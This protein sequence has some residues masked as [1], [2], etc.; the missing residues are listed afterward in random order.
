MKKSIKKKIA[1]SATIKNT[2]LESGEISVGEKVKLDG[3][4]I[5][6]KKI[7]IKPNAVLTN[8]KLF[9]EGTVFI[10]ENSVIKENAVINAFKGINIGSRTI[11]DRDVIIGG[12]QSQKSEIKIGEDCVVLYRSYVNTTRKILIGNNVGIGGYCLIFSHS[13]WQNAL[14][15][16]PYK[17]ANVIIEDNVWLPWNVTVMPGI[18]VGKNST[19]GSGSVITKNIPSNVFAAGVPAKVIRKRETKK[20]SNFDKNKIMQEVLEDFID[21]L[22]EF[23]KIPNQ[24]SKTG[25]NYKISTKYNSLVYTNNF[26]NIDKSYTIISFRIPDNLKTHYEWIELDSRKSRIKTDLSKHFVTFIRRYGIK[27][28]TN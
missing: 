11:I 15:G 6:A 2:S 18:I 16:N 13:A 21:Y 28:R 5:K 24:V 4:F 22:S 9:S 10:G 8:C 17:F 25:N 1:K 20:L 12:M 23:L 7:V 14:E 27:I 26:K 3:V 19:V